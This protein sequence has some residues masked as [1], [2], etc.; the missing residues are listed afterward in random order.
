M[1]K[2][3]TR[4]NWGFSS[5]YILI[6]VV[7]TQLYSPWKKLIELYTSCIFKYRYS[8]NSCYNKLGILLLRYHMLYVSYEIIK[9]IPKLISKI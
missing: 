8:D 6:W 5:F 4:R 9:I 2:E 7:V 3:R 1:T